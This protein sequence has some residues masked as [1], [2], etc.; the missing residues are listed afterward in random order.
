MYNMN[1]AIN[2]KE[3]AKTKSICIQYTYLTLIKVVSHFFW[4]IQKSAT[5]II[6]YPQIRQDCSD[7][8]V[9]FRNFDCTVPLPGTTDKSTCM[10]K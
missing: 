3:T 9:C 10:Y 2:K 6:A 1:V 4:C 7:Q 5:A 8:R